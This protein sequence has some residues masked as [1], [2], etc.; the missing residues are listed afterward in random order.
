LEAPGADACLFQTRGFERA[1]QLLQDLPGVALD[2][3]PQVAPGHGVGDVAATFVIVPRGDAYSVNAS[4]DNNGVEATG[5]SRGTLALSGHNHFGLG[6]DYAAS[7]TGSEKSMWTGALSAGLPVASGGL[8][9]NGGFTRQQ[10]TVSSGGTTFVGGANTVNAGLTYPF[11]RGLDGNLWGALSYLHSDTPVDYRDFGFAVH[12]KIDSL[13]LAVSGNN[14][15]RARQLRADPWG[16]Q[17]ALTAG[18]QRNDDT[19]DAGPRRAGAYAKLA[20]SAYGSW[21]LDRAGDLFISAR[22]QA[23]YASRNLDP[24]EQL[25]IG[26]PGAVRAYRGDEPTLNE[27]VVLGLGLT[28]RFPVALGHQIQVGPVLDVA[29]GRVNHT[30]WDGWRQSY[31]AGVDAKNARRLAGWGLEA[32]W[33]TPVGAT[34]TLSAAKAFGFSDGSWIEPDKEPVQYWFTL[35]W[36]R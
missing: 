8:R 12:S 3:A 4:V 35:S 17:L 13:K 34:V 28:R 1:T 6:E 15:E 11:T 32:S 5:R 27:G 19:L 33:L 9:A 7:L 29:A 20:A 36:N 23:Q 2:G 24:S 14:G 22:G 31:P 21:A 25:S 16:G 26:G 10:Y 30:A 18:R